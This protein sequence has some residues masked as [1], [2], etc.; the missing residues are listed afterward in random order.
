MKK[1]LFSFCFLLVLLV[2]KFV[3]AGG[4]AGSE[5]GQCGG[6]SRIGQTGNINKKEEVTFTVSGL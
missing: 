1:V 6:I 3:K 4:S 5:I 2:G